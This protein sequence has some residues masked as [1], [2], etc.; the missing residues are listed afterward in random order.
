MTRAPIMTPTMTPSTTPA[1]V[2]AIPRPRRRPA[3]APGTVATVLAA[4][5]AMSPAMGPAMAQT[6]TPAADEAADQTGSGGTAPELGARCALVAPM[7]LSA[8]IGLMSE[9][10]QA[11]SGAPG[12]GRDGL[13]DAV[14]RLERLM[15]LHTALGC[16]TP[17]LAA[18]I[19][20]LAERA[21]AGAS[22]AGVQLAA[23]DCMRAAGLPV[24]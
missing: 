17:A 23:R 21:L 14:G 10:G 5:L 20:C 2:G 22:E 12:A 13:D 8:W 15:A 11:S 16:D 18:A 24:R 4:A 19:D 3:P 7:A 9:I 1:T 6:P